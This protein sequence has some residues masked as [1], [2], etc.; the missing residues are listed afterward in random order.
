M[1]RERDS[2]CWISNI[3]VLKRKEPTLSTFFDSLKLPI[4]SLSK[5]NAATWQAPVFELKKNRHNSYTLVCYYYIFVSY[6]DEIYH[7]KQFWTLRIIIQEALTKILWSPSSLPIIPFK[8]LFYTKIR[9][10]ITILILKMYKYPMA[11]YF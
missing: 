9:F 2:G 11:F 4:W 1:R 10:T 7:C 8:I 3:I 6:W 5:L